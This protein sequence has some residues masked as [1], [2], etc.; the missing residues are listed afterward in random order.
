VEFKVKLKDKGGVTAVRMIALTKDLNKF[1]MMEVWWW[2]DSML[3]SR[4]C[5]NLSRYSM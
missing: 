2:F 3:N 4:R 1:F 5:S